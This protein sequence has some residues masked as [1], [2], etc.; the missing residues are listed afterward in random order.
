MSKL[1]GT[2][3]RNYSQ[4]VEVA[5]VL[6]LLLLLLAAAAAARLTVAVTV[7]AAAV[8]VVDK[9]YTVPHFTVP[10]S[11]YLPPSLHL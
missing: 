11:P 8:V 4:S 1:N 6:I 2:I 7:A 9:Y 5:E 10:D 3:T